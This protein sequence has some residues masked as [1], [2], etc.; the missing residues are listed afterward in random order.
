MA[1]VTVNDLLRLLQDRGLTLERDDVQWAFESPHDK[2][3]LN[4]WLK[5][6]SSPATLLS[7]DEAKL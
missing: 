4:A 5:E 6:Y 7:L 1:S 3:E 2:E